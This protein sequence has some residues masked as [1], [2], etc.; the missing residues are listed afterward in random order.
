MKCVFI[1]VIDQVSW[2]QAAVTKERG[3]RRGRVRTRT[4]ARGLRWRM[5]VKRVVVVVVLA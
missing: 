2:I 1:C 4:R 5:L 3:V